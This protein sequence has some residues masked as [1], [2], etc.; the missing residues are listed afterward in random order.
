MTILLAIFFLLNRLYR[1]RRS[2]WRHLFWRPAGI[3]ILLVALVSFPEMGDAEASRGE[4]EAADSAFVTSATQFFVDANA[5]KEGNG[6]AASPF[7]TIGDALKAASYGDAI[8][9][10]PGT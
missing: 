4:P 2:A 9:L 1:S 8:L 7:R 5:A 10:A 6:N 3:G